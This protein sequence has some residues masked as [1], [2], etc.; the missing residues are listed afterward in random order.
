MIFARV[1]NG[2]KEP[3]RNRDT[4]GRPVR[5]SYV[6]TESTTGVLPGLSRRVRWGTRAGWTVGSAG[7]LRDRWSAR[8]LASV[9]PATAAEWECPAVEAVCEG[10]VESGAARPHLPAAARC[11]GEQR[12]AVGTHLYEARADLAIALDLAHS[13][14]RRRLTVL[15]ALTIGW[16]EVGVERL[17]AVPLVDE[18]ADMASLGYLRLRLRELYREA[19]LTGRDVATDHLLVVVETEPVDGAHTGQRLVA[20]KVSNRPRFRGCAAGQLRLVVLSVPVALGLGER[21]E[22]HVERV[23]VERAGKA[24]RDQV[25]SAGDRP[26]APADRVVAGL[27]CDRDRIGRPVVARDEVR[28]TSGHPGSGDDECRRHHGR[29][30]RGDPRE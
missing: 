27:L 26:D 6:R 2:Q 28:P 22:R 12:A 11:L 16:A 20:E 13:G 24:R 23:V 8:S 1:E 25:I 14:T 4:I 5:L 19:S 7:A 9:W 3:S 21:I 18:R 15:D 17:A 10:L 30:R 29:R